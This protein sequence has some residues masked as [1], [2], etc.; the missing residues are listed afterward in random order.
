[1]FWI[2][3]TPEACNTS[4]VDDAN[5]DD[6]TFSQA[7]ATDYPLHTESGQKICTNDDDWYHVRLY[8]GE[9]LTIDVSF[10]QASFAEDLDVHLYKDFTDLWPCSPT[11]FLE[12]SAARGQSATANEHAEYTVPTGTCASGCDYYVVVRGWD[13]ASNSYGITLTVE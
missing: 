3:Q 6:D 10:T 1:L 8:E 12:C 2:D 4:C 5:E 13:G 9:K 11:D 7:R